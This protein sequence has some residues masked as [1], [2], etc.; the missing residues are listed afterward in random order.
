MIDQQSVERAAERFR[1][2]EGSFERMSLRRE[3][4]HRNRRIRAGAL[5]VIVALAT[6]IILVRSLTSKGFRPIPCPCRRAVRCSRRRSGGRSR[7]RALAPGTWS[8]TGPLRTARS[9]PRRRNHSCC[10]RSRTSTPGCRTPSVPPSSAGRGPCPPT[11]SRSRSPSDRRRTP[12]DAVPGRSRTFGRARSRASTSRTRAWWSPVPTR[13]IA[14]ERPRPRSSIR[15][16]RPAPLRSTGPAGVTRPMSSTPGR[17][18]PRRRRSRRGRRTARWS[19]PYARSRAGTSVG[20]NPSR[21]RDRNRSR[22]R[23]GP[24]PSA[25]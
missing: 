4:R 23:P 2:P 10:S 5:G 17:T 16:S 9:T 8:I 12:P 22:R 20:E 14:I 1:L 7:C 13:P 24:R 25:P 18:R 3:R 6:G 11:A 21:S 15:S 19:S